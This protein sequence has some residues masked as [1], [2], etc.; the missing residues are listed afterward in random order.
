MGKARPIIIETKTFT[1][2]G[3]ARKFFSE[4]LQGYS[5]GD[6]IDD[7]DTSHLT[8]LL[9]RHDEE[10]EKVGSGIAHISVGPAPDY[11]NER[12]FWI[13][14]TDGSRIDFSYQHCLLKKPTD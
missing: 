11:I 7:E 3:D 8:A 4:M 12:C 1:K 10:V 6:R 5:V 14:R 13:T 9:R 2:V